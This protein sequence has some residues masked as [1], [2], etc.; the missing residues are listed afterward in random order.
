M[1]Q[2]CYRLGKARGAV[3]VINIAIRLVF[4]LGEDL[5]IS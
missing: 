5:G 1:G 4:E 2:Y 3:I